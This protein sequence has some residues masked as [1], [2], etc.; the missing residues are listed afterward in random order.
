MAL[1]VLLPARRSGTVQT[2][3][4][5]DPGQNRVVA[6]IRLDPLAVQASTS[7]TLTIE[8]S[9]DGILWWPL[10]GMYVR[11][12]AEKLAQPG[13]RGAP[14][15][16]QLS[17]TE[18]L[19]RADLYRDQRYAD[20]GGFSHE[21]RRDEDGA[22]YYQLA[23]CP[24]VRFRVEVSRPLVYSLDCDILQ[25]PAPPCPIGRRSASLLGTFSA[26]EG[27]GALTTG[28]RTTTSG[29]LITGT[30]SNWGN[31]AYADLD[32]CTD[33][34]SNTYTRPSTYQVNF[35]SGAGSFASVGISYNMAGTRGASHTVSHVDEVSN[36]LGA[37]EWDGVDSTPTVVVNTGSTGSSTAPSDGCGSVSGA[38]LVILVFGYD[39]SATTASVSDGTQ[40]QKID[41]NNDFQD[42]I[43][44]YKVGQTGSP[45]ITGT[46]AASRSWG[47][48]AIAF[49]ESASGPTN[50]T[51]TVTDNLGLTDTKTTKTASSRVVSDTGALTDTKATKTASSRTTT[52]TAGVT[53]TQSR[54]VASSRLSTDSAALTDT[55][56]RVAFSSRISTDTLALTDTVTRAVES[57]RVYTDTLALTDTPL[58]ASAL[59]RVTTDTI[60]VSDSKLTATSSLRINTDT[61][62]LNDSTLYSTAISRL[63]TDTIALSDSKTT[64]S[65]FN[66]F[67]TD[68]IAVNDSLAATVTS[69]RILSDSIGVTDSIQ[70]IAQCLRAISDTVGVTDL[71]TVTGPGGHAYVISVSESLGFSD[72]SKTMSAF[73]R[74]LNDT[75]GS[76]DSVARAVSTLLKL[77]DTLGLTDRVVART[78]VIAAPALFLTGNAQRNVMPV[79]NT[80]RNIMPSANAQ[81]SMTLTASAEISV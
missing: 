69:L 71:T 79:E 40:A 32:A 76:A 11:D 73:L 25:R 63:N 70:R 60:G 4:Q 12:V 3:I 68:T 56:A 23:L 81:R 44:H 9:P 55:F 34:K 36:G 64:S 80:Q 46:L 26:A 43:V 5:P 10:G 6:R 21:L 13:R 53:D 58:F 19:A 16:L 72:V 67:T 29:S 52:D 49:L 74:L 78:T 37:Q 59:S 22:H 7:L 20:F 62:G 14:D 75:L 48:L 27:A 18:G 65:S 38:S 66:R 61:A 2:T 8:Q 41:E 35:S 39:G 45:T 33:S 1:D 50:Y 51:R 47:A 54:T 42:C 77:A 24:R 30:P 28:S 57:K 15:I 17:L 31:A